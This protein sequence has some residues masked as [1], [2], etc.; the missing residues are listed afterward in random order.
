MFKKSRDV[1]QPHRHQP[2][3]KALKLLDNKT[4]YLKSGISRPGVNNF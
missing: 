3:G 1:L 4:D 2:I